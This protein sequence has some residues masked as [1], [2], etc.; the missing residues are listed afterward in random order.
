M[1]HPLLSV[2]QALSSPVAEQGQPQQ[3]SQSGVG[4][5][6]AALG[7]EPGQSLALAPE[8]GSLVLLK[9]LGY[10]HLLQLLQVAGADGS[11]QLVT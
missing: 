11:Q 8:P 10:F 9:Q 4:G 2:A 7:F 6:C 3:V 1:Q 5:V